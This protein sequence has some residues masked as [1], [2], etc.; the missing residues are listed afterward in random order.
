MNVTLYLQESAECHIHWLAELRTCDARGGWESGKRSCCRS[1]PMR[2][3]QEIDHEIPGFGRVRVRDADQAQAF[4]CFAA[5]LPLADTRFIRVDFTL[6]QFLLVR[7]VID[8]VRS[9]APGGQIG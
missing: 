6:Y 1:T 3:V 4:A 7:C 8:H 2:A 5:S 9:H